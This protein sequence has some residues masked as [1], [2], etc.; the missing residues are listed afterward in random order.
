[1]FCIDAMHF[2][3]KENCECKF[4]NNTKLLSK[5]VIKNDKNVG[6]SD[7][8]DNLV[9]CCVR[10]KINILKDNLIITGNEEK[11]TAVLYIQK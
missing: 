6:L 2:Q 5:N 1:M 7:F 11:I 3:K 8:C 9:Q 10:S 4:M